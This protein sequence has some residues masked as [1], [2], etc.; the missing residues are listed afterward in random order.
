MAPRIYERLRGPQLLGPL[1]VPK[2]LANTSNPWAGLTTIASG[3][4][5]VVVSTTLINSDSFVL[6][7]FGAT[8]DQS[9]GKNRAICVRTIVSGVSFI[10]GSPDNQ[11]FAADSVT[12][13][14][15]IL[16]RT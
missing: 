16:V 2:S 3:A 15:W 8:T 9:S 1:T 4:A 12:T 10:L 6:T 14:G 11:A 5:S 7:A 13:V